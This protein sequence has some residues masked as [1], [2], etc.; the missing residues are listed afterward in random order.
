[1]RRANSIFF[2]LMNNAVFGK[3]MENVKNRMDLYMTTENEKAIKWF[4][5]LHFKDSKYFDG[6]H[7]VEMYKH[8]IEYCKPV[9]V[10]TSL[11]DLSKL[12]MMDFH[13][14]TIHENFENKYNL[15]Y[16]DTDSLVYNIKCADVYKWIGEHKQY[17]D[18]SDSKRPELKDDSNQKVL[19]KFKDELNS[20]IMTE[21]LALNPKVYS[22]KYYDNLEY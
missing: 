3:T 5:K 20:L 22:I 2:K 9:Y 11:V 7:V 21:F 6:L 15:I 12:C 18:L 1:M 16:S 4:S 10:G 13:Y 14:N 17:F 19:G 8:Q